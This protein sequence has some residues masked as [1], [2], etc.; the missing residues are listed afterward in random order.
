MRATGSKSAVPTVLM[1]MMSDKLIWGCATTGTG[2]QTPSVCQPLAGQRRYMTITCQEGRQHW[3]SRK[4]LGRGYIINYVY[5]SRKTIPFKKT[6][7]NKQIASMLLLNA[8]SLAHSPPSLTKTCCI[9]SKAWVTWTS[10]LLSPLFSPSNNQAPLGPR[11]GSW[12]I[13][14]NMIYTG[15]V[16]FLIPN[17][18]P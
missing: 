10:R 5:V 4:Q 6:N 3:C 2:P 14:A 1:K 8:I 17:I 11:E 15:E 9:L 18:N 13:N 16:I 7:Q 12:G